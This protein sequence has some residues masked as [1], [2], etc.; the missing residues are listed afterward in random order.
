MVARDSYTILVPGSSPGPPTQ[1]GFLI[2]GGDNF[3]QSYR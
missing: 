2:K 1:V 3:G